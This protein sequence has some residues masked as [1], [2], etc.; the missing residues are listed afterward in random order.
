MKLTGKRV[1]ITGASS[2]LGQTLAW[3][4]A[5]RGCVLVLTSRREDVLRATAEE[6][7]DTYPDLPVPLVLPCDM[8]RPVEIRALI[9]EAERR[10]GGVD[11]LINNAA[12]SLYGDAE[13]TSVEDYRDLMEVDYFGPLAAMREVVPVMKRQENG[14]IVN[15]ASLAAIHG[16]PYLAGYCAAKAALAAV[17]QSLRAE[18]AGTGVGI[19]VVYPDYME[20]PIFVNEKRVGGARRPPGPYTP[21]EKVADA[22][23]KAIET[24]KG[25]LVV[26]ARGKAMAFTSGFLPRIVDRVMAL[27]ASRYRQEVRLHG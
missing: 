7:R 10:V 27:L 24:G 3:A 4:L 12:I 20:T 25:E 23:L 26:S 16:V 8:T 14:L 13:R 2:G 1:L 6:I 22:I 19:L 15:V 21:P 17:S 9:E 11:I 18:L 5:A